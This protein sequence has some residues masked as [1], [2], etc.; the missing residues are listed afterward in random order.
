MN[1]KLNYIL[2]CSLMVCSLANGQDK[3][4]KEADADFNSYAYAEAIDSYENLVKK[5]YTSEEIFKNLGDANYQ[6]A[7]Y[8][9]ASDWYA[10]LFSLEGNAT[11]TEY[12]YKYAQ[13][14]KSLGKYSESD[15]WMQKFEAAKANDNRAVKFVDNQDYLNRIKENSGRYAIKNLSINSSASDFA[16]SFHGEEFVFSSAR[17]TGRIA[18]SIHE[19]NNESFTNLYRT[20]PLKNG[21]FSSVEKLSKSLNKKTHESSTAFTKDGNTVYFTRNNSENG[22]F[23]RD[24]K[25]LSR[26]KI[27]RANLKEG[28][29]KDI[30][31][32]PFNDDS[33]S[34]AHPTLSFDEKKLYF[35]SDMPGSLRQSDIFVVDIHS[36]GGFS[37]P[38]NL[39]SK[40]NTE[41]RETF[42]FVTENNVIYFA[43]DGR[44]GL[45]GLDIF[46]T[47]I[48]DMDNLYIVNVGE[49][50]NGKQ[51]DFSFVLNENTRKGFF[52][53]NREGGLGNDDIYSFTENIK[54]DLSCNFIVTGLIRDKDTNEPLAGSNIVITDSKDQKV[55]ETAS[56]I[57]GTFSLEGNC[58]DGEYR[59]MASKDKYDRGDTA[60]TVL[61]SNDLSGIE[62]SLEKTIKRATAGTDLI[63]FLQ[64]TPVY[65]DL[66][67]SDIRPDTETTLQEVI[68]YLNQF[69]ELKIEVQSHTDAKANDAYNKE[70][71]QRR[72]KETVAYLLANGIGQN[73]VTGQGYGESQLANDCT[74]REKCVD[75]EHQ[76]NRRSEFIVLE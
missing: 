12:L 46:A 36:D 31:E 29:W 45:G 21:N 9:V 20:M 34:V 1:K 28:E 47:K 22:K 18:R 41:A 37:T 30:I 2:L 25:G 35:A 63:G 6:N 54:I 44:P 19:W 74:S 60:F 62:I 42:P 51:D 4:S 24:E 56:G 43:S 23:S 33:Y 38:K 27:Y 70:L 14:L 72:A 52:A 48:D 26:L 57:D 66:D 55:S 61:N 7:N 49:P 17:D 65:F 32:L 68:S 76:T 5:G 11:E 71:S 40:I 16:P 59:L 69:P 13:T 8:G 64:L 73:R 50:V 39:G 15:Q 53:S 3:K 10:K 67:E 75:S 58:R